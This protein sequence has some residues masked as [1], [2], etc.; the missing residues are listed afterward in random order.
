MTEVARPLHQKVYRAFLL[1]AFAA[2]ALTVGCHHTP[3]VSKT[4]P[5]PP[6]PAARPTVTLTADPTP[7]NKG[8]SATL[9]YS[10]TNPTSSTISPEVGAVAPQGSTKVSPS[11][12]PTN[13]LT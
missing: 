1:T 3:V 13:S 4:E 12:Q 11:D 7:I 10:S 5:P 8:D 2:A 6:P 9:H